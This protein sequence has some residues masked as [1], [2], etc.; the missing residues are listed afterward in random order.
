MDL[1]DKTVTVIGLARSGLAAAQLLYEKHAKVK[2]TDSG[3]TEEVKKNARKLRKMGIEVQ[4]G[5]HTEDFI[6]GS[7]LIV[8][9]PGVYPESGVLKL[10][11]Q[12]GIPIISEIELGYLYCPTDSIVA[13]TGTN[14]KS[15]TVSLIGQIL[16]DGR[17]PAVV[18]GNVGLPFC[19]QIKKLKKHSIVV[20]EVSSFQLEMID[21]FRPRVS[22]ILNVS[23]NHLDRHKDF[24]EYLT[25]KLNIFKNQTNSDYAILNFDDQNLEGLKDKVKPKVLYF[26]RNKKISGAYIKDGFIVLSFGGK[27]QK[28]IKTDELKI[29]GIHNLENALCAVCVGWIFKVKPQSMAKTLKNFKGLE[30]RFEYVANIGGIDFINDSKATTPEAAGAA[31]SSINQPIILIAGG[32]D[33]NANFTTI[34]DLVR[35]KVKMC[36]LVGEAKEKIRRQLIDAINFKEA[37]SLV[38]AVKVAYNLADRGDCILLSPMCTSFDMFRDFEER[39]SVFKETV[40]TLKAK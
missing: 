36:V 13:V 22:A 21:K 16:K 14:G 32:R 34:K 17:R 27:Q 25:A 29:K 23:Q 11:R 18:C 38:D 5:G 40:K 12:A 35:N 7:D 37:K 8:T 1:K 4:T 39:G 26:S 6:L 31:L 3:Q 9:S 24:N 33:K 2:V 30:H 20:L 28:V 15:T 10:A 19:G